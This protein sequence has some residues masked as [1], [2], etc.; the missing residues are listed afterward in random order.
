MTKKNETKNAEAA[1]EQPT[2]TEP[3]ATVETPDTT[4][5]AGDDVE[6]PA[7][8]P[9]DIPADEPKDGQGVESVTVIVIA[10]QETRGYLACKSV[11]K[12]LHGVDCDVH[13][14]SDEHLR[15]NL[16]E[17][18]KEHLPY[19]KTERIILMTEN[20]VI[21]NP[22][23]LGDIAVVKA[24]AVGTVLDFNTGMPVLMHKSALQALISEAVE[25]GRLDIDVVNTY[26]G[27][28]LPEGFRPLVLGEWK[29]DPWLLPVVSQSPSVDAIAKYAEWKK[30]AVISDVSWSDDVVYFLKQRLE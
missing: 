22:I 17:T 5:T 26:F 11:E 23:T 19:I 27:G 30:F 1:E 12:Y 7:D 13:L 8:I 4:T 2:K 16:V 28:T 29:K 6:R 18:L 24:K 10:H 9:A 3:V 20:M 14:V 15:E 25:A 21:L